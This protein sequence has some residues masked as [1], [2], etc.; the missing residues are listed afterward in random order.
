MEIFDKTMVLL[1]KVMDLRQENQQVFASNIANAYTPGYSPAH[2]EF[3]DKL[4]QALAN[5]AMKPAATHPD[6]FPI[7]ASTLENVQADVIRSRNTER[8]GDGNGVSVDQEMVL[9]SENQIL[10]EAAVQMFNKKL[11]LLKYVAQDGK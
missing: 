3:E 8:I 11:G 10:Y 4:R 7:G 1:Q 2:L 9:L 6:H 5:S